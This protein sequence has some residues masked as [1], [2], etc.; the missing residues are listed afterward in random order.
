MRTYEEI[1]AIIKSMDKK[2]YRTIDRAWYDMIL[3]TGAFRKDARKRFLEN[4]KK[5]GLTEAEYD[6]YKTI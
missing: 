5:V 2:T 3:D 1:A 4:I 6:T